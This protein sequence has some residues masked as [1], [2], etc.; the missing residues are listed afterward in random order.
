MVRTPDTTPMVAA[1]VVDVF[2]ANVD[3]V[4][5]LTVIESC[6]QAQLCALIYLML[7]LESKTTLS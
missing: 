3:V 1:I 6:L 4:R 7:I 2:V 5:W